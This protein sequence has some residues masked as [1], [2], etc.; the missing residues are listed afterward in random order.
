MKIPDCVKVDFETEPIFRRPFYPPKAVGLAIQF[1]GEKK[2]T[3]GAWGHKA[4]GNTHPSA[5]AKQQLERAWKSDYPLLMQHGKFDYAVAQAQ[6]GMPSLSWERLHDTEFLLFLSD[7]HASTLALKPSAHRILGIPPDEQDKVKD[8]LIAN[9]F[10]KKNAKRWGEF[11]HQAPADIVAPYANGDN[12]RTDKLFAHLYKEICD[13]GMLDAY[14]RERRLMPI[15]LRSEREG[16]RANTPRLEH[17]WIVYNTAL[18]TVDRIL[19]KRLH[20]PDLNLDADQQLATVFD[21]EGIVSEWTWTKG[22][23]NRAPQRSVSKKNLT[24]DKFKNREI[25]LL[26]GYRVRLS[27]CLSMFFE[28]WLS[29][30]R[31]S[32]GWIYT[33]WNQVRQADYGTRTGRLSSNPN[34]QNIPTDFEEK[35]DGYEHAAFMTKLGLPP[36][37]MMRVY[38]LPDE[39]CLWIHRDYNQQEL[40]MLAH[41]EDG[42][43]CARYNREP[44]FDIHTAVQEGIKAI[45]QIEL[46]RRG[47]KIV[48]FS[49]IYGKGKSGLAKDLKV[50]MA[51]ADLIKAA[52]NQ[53][54]PGIDAL[55]RSIKLRGS[56][57]QTIRTWGGREYYVEAE[58][59]SK[60]YNRWMTFEYKLLNYL[61]Q[62]SAGD[63]TK[64]ATI[65]YDEHPKR[66]SRFLLTVHDE[67][68]ASSPSKKG[69]SPKAV[70]DMVAREQLVLRECMETVKVDVPMLSDGKVGVNWGTLEQHDKPETIF[71]RTLS[72]NA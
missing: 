12:F 53:L 23:K 30:A 26:Y 68:N 21:R 34:F 57:G 58:G 62:G 6:F 42:D 55:N 72:A 65:V 66:E 13:R 56:S 28:P 39:N 31:E 54:M 38:L 40:R 5:W 32:N 20:A 59:M 64:E 19:R 51:T 25:A 60:K 47:T 52:K 14:N 50:D 29:M 24:I 43:L 46:T 11:I 71:E 35:D 63:V 41:F 9:R 2:S 10:I 67:E 27:T 33:N 4:G 7:P 69:L 8:W 36:L 22:G 44:R 3:Y 48:N 49:D 37:P 1:P 45:A 61:I 17:D 18:Q 70:K 16:I 15:L